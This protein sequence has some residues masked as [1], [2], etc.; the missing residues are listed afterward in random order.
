LERSLIRRKKSQGQKTDIEKE[1]SFFK[2]LLNILL[3]KENSPHVGRDQKVLVAKIK[4]N[5]PRE[6]RKL[7]FQNP[8]L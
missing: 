1:A 4:M 3:L 7:Q 8:R 6:R 2:W 5:S